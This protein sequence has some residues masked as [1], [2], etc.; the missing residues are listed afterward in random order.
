MNLLDAAGTSGPLT[1]NPSYIKAP[2]YNI[3]QKV[4]LKVSQTVWSCFLAAFHV[5]TLQLRNNSVI[6]YISSQLDVTWF[7]FFILVTLHVSG[8]P[9]PSSG[10]NILHG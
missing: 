10:V 7:S 2:Q 9:C 4:L 8:I 1:I 6:I 3:S 5:Y